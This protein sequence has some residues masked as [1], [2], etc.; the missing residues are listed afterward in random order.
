MPPRMEVF[1]GLSVLDLVSPRRFQG[2]KQA[3]PMQYLLAQYSPHQRI[4][5]LLP[6][7]LNILSTPGLQRPLLLAL[8]PPSEARPTKLMTKP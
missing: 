1:P 7:L 8:F 2:D 3:I 6:L 4:S 5:F